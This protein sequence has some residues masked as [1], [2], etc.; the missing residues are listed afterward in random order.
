MQARNL[1]RGL[2]IAGVTALIAS[3]VWWEATHDAFIRAQKRDLKVDH[4]L[5]CLVIFSDRCTQAKPA[6]GLFS[7]ASGYTPLAL[8]LGLALVVAGLTVVY[9]SK[10]LGP[11]PATPAGEPKLLIGG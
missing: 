3:I 7:G 9:R 1:G 2:V 10:P 8:W 6:A 5:D 4:P 11:Y